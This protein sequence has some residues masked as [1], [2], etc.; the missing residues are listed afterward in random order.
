[1]AAVAFQ[2][3]LGADG[4]TPQLYTQRGCWELP[5]AQSHWWHSRAVGTGCAGLAGA[6]HQPRA[7][8]SEGWG[9]LGSLR[10]GQGVRTV[11]CAQLE[12]A[13]VGVQWKGRRGGCARAGASMQL[14]VQGVQAQP[15]TPTSVAAHARACTRACA[16]VHRHG[17]PC[18]VLEGPGQTSAAATPWGSGTACRRC[19]REPP[20]WKWCRAGAQLCA[21]HRFCRAPACQ[22]SGEQ[23]PVALKGAGRAPGR[24]G[25]ESPGVCAAQRRLLG[26]AETFP[27]PHHNV[28]KYR[29]PLTVGPLAGRARGAPGI[30]LRPGAHQAPRCAGVAE[31]GT[32]PSPAPGTAP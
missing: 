15:H 19:R 9:D 1:M 25:N 32:E 21:W 16:S 4:V 17:D 14:C 31:P 2:K 24:D 26:W 10:A 5:G 3:A 27:A 23:G 20:G 11:G 13:W 30:P 29:R 18:W 8:C 22:Q 12:L 7:P 6:A 28:C